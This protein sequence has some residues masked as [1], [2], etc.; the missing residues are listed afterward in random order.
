VENET[1]QILRGAFN[2]HVKNLWS[3]PF[4]VLHMLHPCWCAVA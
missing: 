2:E 1:K 4:E 3:Q